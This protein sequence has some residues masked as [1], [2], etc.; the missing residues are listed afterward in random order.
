MKRQGNSS[1]RKG[2][3][4]IEVESL[5]MTSSDAEQLNDEMGYNTLT[6]SRPSN[7]RDAPRWY[8]KHPSVDVEIKAQ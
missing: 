5:S 8:V 7:S 1:T 3:H 4:T 6:R 2:P